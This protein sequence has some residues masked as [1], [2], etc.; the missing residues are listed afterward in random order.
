MDITV[1]ICTWNRADL[2]DVTLR[3]MRHLRIPPS[4]EWELLIVN[5][6]CSDH[7]DAVIS[8]HSQFLPI[9]RI[10]ETKERKSECGELNN[11]TSAG[12]LI[13]WTDDDVL[14]DCEWL[15]EYVQASNTWRDAHFF[16]GTVDPFFEIEPPRWMRENLKYIRSVY[17]IL[18]LGLTFDP[19]A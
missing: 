2:L 12:D 14:V 17:A 15:A 11:W 16:G 9:R 18:Q 6:N 4:V 8:R 13:L 10:F 7:T 19:A 5:N 3:Y 1:A